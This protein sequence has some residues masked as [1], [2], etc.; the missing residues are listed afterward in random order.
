MSN[1]SL[2]LNF[3]FRQSHSSA[4]S[5]ACTGRPICR[6]CIVGYRQAA[7]RVR[8]KHQQRAGRGAGCD[9]LLGGDAQRGDRPAAA[10]VPHHALP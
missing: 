7:A 4:V 9:A 2:L 10:L 8:R 1:V 3:W 6:S 5:E